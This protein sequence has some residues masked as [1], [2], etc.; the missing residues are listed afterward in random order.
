MAMPDG[1]SIPDCKLYIGD[2][3]YACR[4]R[5]LPPIRK[6]RYDLDEFSARNYPKIAESSFRVKVERAFGASKNRLKILDQKA[7]HPFIPKLSLV[8]HV[9]LF[10]TGS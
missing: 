9:A 4:P 3:G 1:I 6:T 2:V 8:L 10:I 7:F 5:V